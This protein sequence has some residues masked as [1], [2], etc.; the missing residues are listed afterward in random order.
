[1]NQR[2]LSMKYNL[3]R[4]RLLWIWSCL[5]HFT[6]AVIYFKG[7]NYIELYP[8]VIISESVSIFVIERFVENTIIG[9]KNCIGDIINSCIILSCECIKNLSYGILEIIICL[10]I[11]FIKQNYSCISLYF[12]FWSVV[13]Q[14]GGL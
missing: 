5:S 4:L 2:L 9:Y 7:A 8:H 10:G 14:L 12:A 11:A 1:M 3:T 6:C 13:S